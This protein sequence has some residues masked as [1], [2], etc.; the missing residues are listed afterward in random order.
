MAASTTRKKLLTGAIVICVVLAVL[1]AATMYQ[2]FSSVRGVCRSATARYPGD[3]V[4]A[5]IALIESDDASF[6]EKNQAI[7]ALGQIGDDRAL[8]VLRKLDSEEPQPKPYNADAYIVQY[9]VEKAIRQ[10]EGGFIMTRW[11]YYWL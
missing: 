5:L 4:E 11:M 1:F 7:W 9:S 6:R 10:I 3:N 2:I 8:P